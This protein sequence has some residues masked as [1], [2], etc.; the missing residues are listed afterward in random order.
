MKTTYVKNV[1][2]VTIDAKRR[3]NW[4]YGI[5]AYDWK[6]TGVLFGI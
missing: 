1:K 2:E 5:W 6:R 4:T 3:R